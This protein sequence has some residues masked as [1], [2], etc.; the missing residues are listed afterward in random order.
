MAVADAWGNNIAKGDGLALVGVVVEEPGVQ[1]ELRVKISDNHPPIP[2]DA[3]QAVKLDAIP[4]MQRWTIVAGV[5]NGG[6]SQT[7]CLVITS[8]DTLPIEPGLGVP[9]P[10]PADG[11]ILTDVRGCLRHFTGSDPGDWTLAIKRY[12]SVGTELESVPIAVPLDNFAF[13]FN[14]FNTQPSMA[15][16]VGEFFGATFTGPAASYLLG[17]FTFTFERSIL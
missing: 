14:T 16:S 5:N 3:T 7:S 10:V 1:T 17:R 8:S 12:N 9:I 11:M 4:Q 15:F 2:V 13:Q 6:T